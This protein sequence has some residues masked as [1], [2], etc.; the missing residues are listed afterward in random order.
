MDEA[1]A[2]LDR[3]P[4]RTALVTGAAGGIGRAIAVG[5]AEPGGRLLL[6]GRRPGP[7]EETAGLIRAAGAAVEIE[8]GDL[9]DDETVRGLAGRVAALGRLDTLVHAAG[10]Y[11]FGPLSEVDGGQ[12]DES[13]AT[14][15]RA[16][17]LLT[18]ALLPA[19][20]HSAGDV[21]FV[22]SSAAFHP[23]AANGPYAAMKSALHASA[24]AFRDELNVDGVRVLSVFPGRTA[25]AMQ[26]ALHR[27]EG[28]TYRPELLVQPEDVAAIIIAALRL[29]RTA[30][31]TEINLRPATRPA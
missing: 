5:L 22:N 25:T 16:P 6:S 26:E 4:V 10:T 23:G 3:G 29:P 18:Q 24:T 21:V 11:M 28:R 7:L 19:L 17:I 14:N 13:Y 12:L 20:R 31:V 30:E 9:T 15:V 27:R 1:I 2:G 8:L